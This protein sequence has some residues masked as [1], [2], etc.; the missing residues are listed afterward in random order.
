MHLHKINRRQRQFGRNDA[1]RTHS[2]SPDR[3]FTEEEN[4]GASLR[5][6]SQYATQ[7]ARALRHPFYRIRDDRSFWQN[8]AKFV[9]TLSV[10]QEAI[11]SQI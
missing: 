7:R 10:M 8:D 3:F 4:W 6:W 1:L 11:K 2:V 5:P 9:C